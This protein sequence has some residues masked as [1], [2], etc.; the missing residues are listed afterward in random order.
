MFSLLLLLASLSPEARAFDGHG[1]AFVPG[2]TGTPSPIA[3]FN[4]WQ[5]DQGS[6]GGSV[7]LEVAGESI[8]YQVGESEVAPYMYG[9]RL[10]NLAGVYAVND[11]VGVGVGLPLYLSHQ[12]LMGTDLTGAPLSDGGAG[13]EGP[14][15]GDLKLWL[16]IGILRPSGDERGLGLS[17]VPHLSLP[18]AN[19][20]LR[21]NPFGAG[22]VLVAGYRTSQFQFSANL[23]A[24]A[25]NGRDPA[26]E[27]PLETLET[28]TSTQ[29]LAGASIGYRLSE[30]VGLNA[31]LIYKQALGSDP[32]NAAN[33]AEAIF[34]GNLATKG[35]AT[36]VVGGA[37]SLNSGAGVPRYRIFLGAR[38]GKRTNPPEGQVND[39]ISQAQTPYDLVL[40][41]RDAQGK[42]IQDAQVTVLGGPVP[43]TAQSDRK[44]QA[45]L[46]LSEGV[47]QVEVEAP[48]YGRQMRDLVLEDG[49]QAPPAVIAVMHPD[50]GESSL[51]LS[52][53]DTEDRGLDGATLLIDG[54][55]YGTTGPGGGLQIDGLQ[56]GEHRVSATAPGFESSEPTVLMSTP[57]VGEDS[58]LYLE[59][60]PGTLRV[61]VHNSQGGLVTGAQVRIMGDVPIE[62]G[63]LNAEGELYT[64]L[65]DG[66]W[67]V[68]VSSPSHGLQQRV[69]NI[70]TDRKVLNTV[71]VVLDDAQGSAALH[72]SIL[73]PDGN[74]V[75]GV[76]VSLDGVDYGETSNGGSMQLEGLSPGI[77]TLQ[78]SGDRMRD[79]PQIQLELVDGV[80][81][82]LVT[83]DWKPGTLQVVTR[84][85]GERP[86]DAQV[87]FAGPSD[88]P[89]SGVG[90]DGEAWYSLPP[91]DWT[92]GVSA[93]AFGLQ[94]REV[95]IEA[96][97][98]SL[99]LVS[100]VL[101]ETAGQSV[102][103]LR[104]T[105]PDGNPVDGARVALDGEPI[106][107][108]S[109]GGAMRV[110]GLATGESSVEVAGAMFHYETVDP[111]ALGLGE[112]LVELPLR[113]LDGTVTV[114]TTGPGGVPVDAL[115][116]AYGPTVLP[117]VQVGK[118]G[119]RVLYLEPGGWTVVASSERMG[120]EEGDV[121]V[122]AG[123]ESL[124][125]V[126][127]S[128]SEAV[129]GEN[130][131]LLVVQ[132]PDGKGIPGAQITMGESSLT[133]PE[134]GSL[135]MDGVQI[136]P[137]SVAI[138]AKG[139]KS[140]STETLSIVPGEQQRT[141]TLDFVP[142][143]V[144]VSVQDGDGKPLQAELFWVGP[145]PVPEAQTNSSG[146]A[147]LQLRPGEWVL[148]V[149]AE[150]L[151]AKRVELEILPG[152]APAP[153]DITLGSSRV[154]VTTGQVVIKEQVFFD[155][156][157]ATIKPESLPLL[158]EVA[159]ALLLNTDITLVEI[160]GHTDNVGN[161]E[162]NRR[163]SQR[164]AQAV[165]DYLVSKG[166]DRRR[167]QANGYGPSTPIQ[168]NETAAG[169]AANRRVQ[170]EIEETSQP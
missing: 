8:A 117:P 104:V 164:R 89:P 44:G 112:N 103:V 48:G 24:Q 47:W 34:S 137:V 77:T 22:A 82:L 90:P 134:G 140:L 126:T 71:D 169:R 72:L 68:V 109:T 30:D 110:E 23:G 15:L 156:G 121:S 2:Q 80:R 88:L 124:L 62:P 149:Q 12:D 86:I 3:N 19:H 36:I 119:E 93:P 100:A 129:A 87:R 127:F 57:S 113:W 101:R 138:T 76:Q 67:D 130:S 145:T 152:A 25:F 78:V 116:R 64:Q 1:Q 9:L 94:T 155:T 165:R 33:T 141:Y 160:Q 135:L 46:P 123:Q 42:S 49:R 55:E 20:P 120:I 122:K 27:A 128:L 108:T 69:V 81:Q 10:A 153:I 125:P 37:T 161:A 115:I 17:V 162:T 59:R 136:G 159:S 39:G 91:G 21:G 66:Q 143:P 144:Q 38:F 97:E 84:G 142:Q 148:V 14:G 96:D 151:G 54:A 79:E 28:E 51:A 4:P 83:M 32:I 132:D 146:K 65:E 98:T 50:A 40:E 6:W 73:D 111:L 61:R 70:D 154:E 16:P 13:R 26:L 114:K 56:E 41:V 105:D 150:G 18:T 170:F 163:L 74:P 11:R 75:Q 53:R 168:D 60:P 5:L 102:L 107:R 139:Y 43:M 158:D 133:S 131:L 29:L 92:V 35:P 63:P 52:L 58:V 85:A 7:L 166:V 167:L 45:I 106:G 118:S 147:D 157:K 95:T 31:E 99:I